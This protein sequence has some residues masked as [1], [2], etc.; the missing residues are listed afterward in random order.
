MKT[1]TKIS[2]GICRSLKALF[3][4]VLLCLISIS[5]FGQE[6][7]TSSQLD[8]I[9]KKLMR[10]SLQ[11]SDSVIIEFLN[12]KNEYLISVRQIRLNG[13]LNRRQ[14]NDQIQNLRFQTNNA[15]RVMLGNEIYD[16]YI[17]MITRRM[18]QGVQGH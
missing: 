15:L 9:Q 18:R 7:S 11:M 3:L 8:S 2:S 5:C 1:E 12:A 16:R 10:D 6:S 13:A 4:N 14:Q 17:Q